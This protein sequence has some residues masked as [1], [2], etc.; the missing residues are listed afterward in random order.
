MCHGVVNTANVKA[1]TLPQRVRFCS[2]R[3]LHRNAAA[4]HKFLLLTMLLA[5][6]LIPAMAARDRGARHGLGRTIVSL[7]VFDVVYLLAL[8]F[9]YPRICW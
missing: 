6:A 1:G 5:T 9:V 4:M 7:A 2:A 3:G 8:M